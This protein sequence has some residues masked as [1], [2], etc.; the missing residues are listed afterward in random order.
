MVWLTSR[1]THPGLD[2]RLSWNRRP[3]CSITFDDIVAVAR[4]AEQPIPVA[5]QYPPALHPQHSTPMEILDD[6]AHRGPAGAEQHRQKFM[7]NGKTVGGD[8]VQGCQNPSGTALFQRV[9]ASAAFACC[10]LRIHIA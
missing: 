8:T 2:S 9:E 1:S 3:T 4:H 7:R 5:E 6:N 10:G